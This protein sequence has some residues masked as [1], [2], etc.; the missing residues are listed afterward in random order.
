MVLKVNQ[1]IFFSMSDATVYCVFYF[2]TNRLS[3]SH[4]KLK[5]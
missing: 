4:F 3:N 2:N 1:L 5:Y